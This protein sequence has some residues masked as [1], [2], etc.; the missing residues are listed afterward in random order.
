MNRRFTT[1]NWVR[2]LPAP[3]GDAQNLRPSGSAG[4]TAVACAAIVLVGPQGQLEAGTAGRE[5]GEGS[6]WTWDMNR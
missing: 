2:D 1:A 4:R 3:R 6:A 5:T